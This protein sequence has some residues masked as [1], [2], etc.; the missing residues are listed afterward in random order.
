MPMGRL[1][2]AFMA[3]CIVAALVPAPANGPPSAHRILT[4]AN[5]TTLTTAEAANATRLSHTFPHGCLQPP[6]ISLWAISVIYIFLWTTSLPS[7]LLAPQPAAAGEKL[8]CYSH[9]LFFRPRDEF[10]LLRRGQ[11]YEI[12]AVAGDTHDQV[13]V[14]FRILLCIK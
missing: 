5:S 13:P 2:A 8:V 14:L 10:H 4:S 11:V 12:R 9:Y 7:P 6:F 1:F 3:A